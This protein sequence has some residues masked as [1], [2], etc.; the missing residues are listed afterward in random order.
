MKK[1]THTLLVAAL[2]ALPVSAHALTIDAMDTVAGL[3]TEI[4][5]TDATPGDKVELSIT[6]PIGN[7]FTHTLNV[8]DAG[9]AHTW[10]A[11]SDLE[12]A[13]EYLLS[14][15]SIVASLE[16][17]PDSI[18]TLQS[19][20]DM[21]SQQIAIGEEVTVTVVLVDR[22]GNPLA[23]RMV[24]LISSRPTDLIQ[25]I[26]RETNGYGEQQFVVRAS[27]NGAL[28][29][30]AM[31]II[32]AQMIDDSIALMAGSITESMGGPTQVA[33]T[34]PRTPTRFYSD[35]NVLG[36]SLLGQVGEFQELD[37]FEIR[38]GDR[39]TSDKPM[40]RLNEAEDIRIT[41]IDQNGNI[42]Q[43]YEGTVYMASTDP[44]A[45]LPKDGVIQF[46][47]TNQGARSFPLV[48]KFGNAGDHII[49][50]TDSPNAAPEDPRDSLG[51]M[52]VSVVGQQIIDKPDIKVSVFEPQANAKF[53]ETDIT[54]TGNGPAFINLTVV[55]GL[56][57]VVGETD[58]DGN[59]AIPITLD[60][61]ETEF[62]IIVKDID[63]RYESEARAF[64][65]DITPPA[66]SSITFTPENPVEETDVLL[67]VQT[68]PGTP[69]VTAEFL[70][71]TYT[72]TNTDP[73][74]GK[75]QML[76]QAP[77]GGGTHDVTVTTSDAIGNTTS[78]SATFGVSLRGL[79]QV[80]SVIAEAQINAIALRWDPVG[81][82][83]EIDGYRIYVGTDPREFLY[84]LDT[85]RPTAAATVAGLRPGTEYFFG[86]TALQEGRESEEESDAVSAIVLGLKL[87]I[88]PGD[89]SVFVEW[90]ALTANVPLSSF[91]L[92]YGTE[93]D[94]FTE[95]RTLNGELRAYT[96]RDL[97]NG[98]TYFVKL[99]PITTTG[100]LLE[101]LSATGQGTPIG[102]GYTAAPGDPIPGGL[103]GA[104]GEFEGPPRTPAVPDLDPTGAPA[105][106][107]WSILAV[108]V[109]LFQV[110][111]RRKKNMQMQTAFMQAMQ[112]RYN[113]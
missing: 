30:R 78:D 20:I 13:G 82:E 69:S 81:E 84:T 86:I 102:G 52:A 73:T 21:P 15:E 9:V 91:L 22:Y 111:L 79:P 3:A 10:I 53:N 26:S 87:E 68:E 61:L 109:V 66:I 44:S 29:L 41:A 65:I 88:T 36:A 96:L 19:Y 11:G 107:L 16:V 98:I 33:Y 7:T 85:D 74:S 14:S 50:I 4:S 8:G 71:E 5:I 63:G 54:V 90:D 28:T 55:G 1:Y 12:V 104:A 45:E 27:T 48:L 62:S 17:H 110:H 58:R 77:E 113:L 32:S 47:F 83:E 60:P 57:D 49:I 51:F 42:F 80:Q 101:D 94:E 24:E 46:G 76:I 59:F 106:M 25:S 31:D 43:D 34:A 93:P 103:H 38:I 2:F 6:P 72:L 70:G 37:H 100:E 75:Y 95:K 105:W 56:E 18:D 35:T 40:L 92:E 112:S 39:I 67:V 89:G 64:S 99:T 108:S 23:G 97:I